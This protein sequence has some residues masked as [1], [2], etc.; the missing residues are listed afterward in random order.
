MLLE[1]NE[2]NAVNSLAVRLAVDS[3]HRASPSEVILLVKIELEH[4]T[5]ELIVILVSLLQATF[6]GHQELG[7][8]NRLQSRE[9]RQHH[10]DRETSR[11][12]LMRRISL[13]T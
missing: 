13:S 12:V 4:S 5:R 9:D 6:G 3:T 10:Y 1:R 7:A 8:K 11:Q 2:R